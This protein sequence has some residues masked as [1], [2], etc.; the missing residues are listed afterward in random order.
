M[1]LKE[2][3]WAASTSTPTTSIVP[4]FIQS[5]WNLK[6]W[7]WWSCEVEACLC[8]IIH[9][10]FSSNY[11]LILYIEIDFKESLLIDVICLCDCGGSQWGKSRNTSST[12]GLLCPSFPNDKRRTIFQESFLST[13]VVKNLRGPYKIASSWVFSQIRDNCGLHHVHKHIYMIC[14]V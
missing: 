3:R 12:S 7:F 2:S 14:K 1:Y 8:I 10:T 13:G 5:R 4:R 6:R 11:I 9:K